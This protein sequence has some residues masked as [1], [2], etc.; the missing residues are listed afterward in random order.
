MSA[1]R[2]VRRMSRRLRNLSGEDVAPEARESQDVD[3]MRRLI[4]VSM[5]NEIGHQQSDRDVPTQ[6]RGEVRRF[7]RRDDGVVLAVEQEYRCRWCGG[8][9]WRKSR[10]VTMGRHVREQERA[11]VSHLAGVQALDQRRRGLGSRGARACSAANSRSAAGLSPRS[12]YEALRK[13]RTASRRGSTCS[14]GTK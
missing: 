7:G 8:S 10:R 13:R 14:G 1:R 3:R 11:Q 2:R 5:R 6:M 12:R 9:G 4:G